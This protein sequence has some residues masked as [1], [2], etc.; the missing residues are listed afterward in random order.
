MV[1]NLSSAK[2]VSKEL[3]KYSSA[4]RAKHAMGFFKTGP[5]QYG[6]G[7]Q[8]IGVTVPNIRAV[9]KSAKEISFPELKKLVSS[10]IHEERLVGFI[11]CSLKYTKARKI[12]D[13]GSEEKIVRFVLKNKKFL[14]N[15][16]II[17]V[18]V[19]N[20]LGF[21]FLNKDRKLLYQLIKSKNLWD[22]RIA[23]M[24]TFAFIRDNDFGDILK[25]CEIVLNDKEDLIHKASGWMLREVGNR[26]KKKLLA[27]LTRHQLDM[28]RTM[29]RYS[30]EKLSK[31]QRT[32][33]LKRQ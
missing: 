26:D 21:Y 15:W 7:D 16:D 32:K 22:R 19:P 23:I 11:I 14:N 20:M 27:F 5:G 24:T 9:A 6:E 33:F 12:G 25:F 31:V 2:E 4:V 10:A 13:E 18:T 1:T 17:D 3:H 29:L 8:F 30:I 28:P